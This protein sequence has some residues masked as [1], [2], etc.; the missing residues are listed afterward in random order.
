[1]TRNCG[2]LAFLTLIAA[3]ASPAPSPNVLCRDFAE[4]DC[5]PAATAARSAAAGNGIVTRVDVSS[6][7]ECPT[8]GLLFQLT[9]CP[10]GS[11]PP[12]EGGEWI[13]HAVV[14]FAGTSAQAH[15][16]LAK[17]DEAIEG[18]LIAVA[19]PPPP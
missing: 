10:A 8:P 11:L 18:Y 19:T 5:D 4:P 2:W 3:C 16:N 6:G 13:G 9:T 17:H 1:M 14:T 7:I 12:P 15:V